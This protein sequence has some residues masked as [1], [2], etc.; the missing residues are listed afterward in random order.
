M[1][2]GTFARLL[3][4]LNGRED[5]KNSGLGGPLSRVSSSVG[6]TMLDLAPQT[7]AG[8]PHKTPYYEEVP[9]EPQIAPRLSLSD[10][11][12]SIGKAT[13]AGELRRLRRSYA[14]ACHPDRRKAA[15]HSAATSEM[16][17]ANELIDRAIASL[18]PR[19]R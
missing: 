9:D 4:E 6:L 16:A 10:L 7:D 3:D 5:V 12:S 14:R 13:T 1:S 19:T 2:A 15:D 18:R 8:S 11:A 17:A